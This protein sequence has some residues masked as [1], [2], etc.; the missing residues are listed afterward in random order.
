M[1]VYNIYYLLNTK[2]IINKNGDKEKR[3]QKQIISLN[4]TLTD[5]YIPCFHPYIYFLFLWY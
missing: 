5:L 4:M 3:K 1:K 2:H